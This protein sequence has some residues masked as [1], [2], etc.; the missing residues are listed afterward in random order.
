MPGPIVRFSQTD[1]NRH[2]TVREIVRDSE[3]GMYNL[4]HV[5]GLAHLEH[6]AV[7]AG[8]EAHQIL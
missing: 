2:F 3:R 1:F 7:H 6:P 4:V 5:T 8:E